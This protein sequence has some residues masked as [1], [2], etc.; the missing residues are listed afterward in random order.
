LTLSVDTVTGLPRT[1]TCSVFSLWQDVVGVAVWGLQCPVRCILMEEDMRTLV[2]VLVV[3][4]SGEGVACCR[5]WSEA[6]HVLAELGNEVRW[7]HW[8]GCRT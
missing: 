8:V 6:G 1:R 7:F 2:E 3:E 4:C 5:N